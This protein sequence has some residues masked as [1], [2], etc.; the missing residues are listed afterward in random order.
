MTDSIQYMLY[1]P[2]SHDVQLLMLLLSMS[3]LQLCNCCCF[4]CC[5]LLNLFV[6]ANVAVFAAIF[7]CAVY[8]HCWCF[9]GCCRIVVVAAV[10]NTA[11]V[12]VAA[13]VNTA[14]V[15]VAA[16]VNIAIVVVAAVVNIAIV[17]FAAG[18]FV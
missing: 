11:F 3:L 15:V 18:V 9:V 5:S 2:Q 14:I 10:V 6:A 12:V 16:V 1:P 13:V 17:G 8:S 4:S 7:G